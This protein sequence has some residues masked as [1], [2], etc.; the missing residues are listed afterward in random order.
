MQELGARLVRSI[1]RI[2]GA[3]PYRVAGWSFGGILAY[4]IARQLI[5]DHETVDFVGLLDAPNFNKLHPQVKA[6]CCNDLLLQELCREGSS[7]S[8]QQNIRASELKAVAQQVEFDTLY[9][10]CRALG[11]LQESL[12]HFTVLEAN[13]YCLRLIA[14]Q[15]A[16]THYIP[17]P[18]G[19]P[20]YLFLAQERFLDDF[21]GTNGNGS[22]LLGWEGLL[23]PKQFRVITVPGSHLSMM[24]DPHIAALGQA[25][26]TVLAKELVGGGEPMEV[27]LTNC[28]TDGQPN[29]RGTSYDP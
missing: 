22:R 25:L 18:I 3:G 4:E 28:V 13:R 26:S 8:A 10:R 21:G 1:R 6:A 12:E 14:H 7:L 24:R 11:L 23:P 17:Q 19:A 15:Y 5:E 20:V 27:A 29:I 2:Q 16:Q 9:Q